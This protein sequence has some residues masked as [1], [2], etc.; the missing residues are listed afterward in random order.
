M[1]PLRRRT[2]ESLGLAALGAALGGLT[3]RRI[4][5]GALGASVGALNGALGGWRGV[6]DLR[7]RRGGVAFVLDSTWAL[8]TTAA[9]LVVHATSHVLG[10]GRDGPGYVEGWSRGRNRHVYAR[11][12][13][14]R[15]G[16]AMAI[17]NVVTGAADAR[18]GELSPRRRR[19][20]DDHEDLHV[21]QARWFG[22][23]FPVGY[24]AWSAVAAVAAVITWPRVRGRQGLGARVDA[25]AYRANPFERW[26]YAHQA[27]R[28]H[29]S[30]V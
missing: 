1:T 19:L 25:W 18:T 14:V 12:W 7:S 24:L 11:G 8:A 21:W 3:G 22:P 23:F 30:A 10:V 27:R 2:G 6:Y 28:R 29:L 13:S 26:A 20:V 15:A 5:I 4:G 17:G 9:A 16:Y